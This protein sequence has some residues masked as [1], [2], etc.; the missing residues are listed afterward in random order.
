MT[1]EEK[2][3]TA[4]F[5]YLS[6]REF[7]EGILVSWPN[8]DFI[9]PNGARY[10]RVEH[11]PNVVT[12]LFLRGDAPNLRQ[13]ILQITAVTPLNVGASS[14]TALAGEIAA[15]FPADLAIFGESVK[16]RIQ[17][18]PSIQPAEKTDVSWDVQVD[19]YYESY[20]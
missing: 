5:T 9:P 14:A 17:S 4:L 16:V 10:I 13:G 8:V 6:E 15:Q 11:M 20:S 3:E 1:I 2:I 12:R 7:I 18:A 19:I